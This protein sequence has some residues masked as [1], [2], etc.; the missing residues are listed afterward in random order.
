MALILIHTKTTKPVY[1]VYEGRNKL[2][3]VEA[4]EFLSAEQ[5]EEFRK[6]PQGY[7]NS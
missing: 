1:S 6:D 5:L 4:G 2:M 7:L 3:T